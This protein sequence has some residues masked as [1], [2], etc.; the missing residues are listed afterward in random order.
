MAENLKIVPKQLDPYSDKYQKAKLTDLVADAVARKDKD[1]LDWLNEESAKKE[2]RTRKGVTSKV[3][4]NIAAI[5]AAYAKKFLNYKPNSKRA[6]ETARKRKQEKAEQE[7]QALF[8][9]AA[10]LFK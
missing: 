2:N 6:A 5:R 10:K 7:R 9:E 8:A 1:A 3:S 4:K